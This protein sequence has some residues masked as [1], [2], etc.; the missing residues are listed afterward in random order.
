[1]SREPPGADVSRGPLKEIR[2]P[3]CRWLTVTRTFR[4]VEG[5]IPPN[6]AGSR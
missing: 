6:A 4:G 2:A 3:E 5:R 1:M